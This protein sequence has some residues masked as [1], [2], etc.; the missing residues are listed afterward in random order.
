MEK[1]NVIFKWPDGVFDIVYTE[2]ETAYRINEKNILYVLDFNS[3]KI[4]QITS[5]TEEAVIVERKEKDYENNDPL[6]IFIELE[7]VNE[8]DLSNPAVLN[9]AKYLVELRDK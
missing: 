6:P 3:L 1:V 4:E 5:E 2:Y 9:F 7:N 8:V